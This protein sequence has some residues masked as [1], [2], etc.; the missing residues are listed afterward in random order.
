VRCKDPVT[1]ELE[2]VRERLDNVTALLFDLVRHLGAMGEKTKGSVRR[3][4][5]LHVAE[6]T[7]VFCARCSRP[8]GKEGPA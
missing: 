6:R 7:E 1:H 4:D 5:R 3:V 2:R 8:D